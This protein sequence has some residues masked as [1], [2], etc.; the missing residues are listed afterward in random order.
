MGQLLGHFGFVELPEGFKYRDTETVEASQEAAR[1]WGKFHAEEEFRVE[2]KRRE[3]RLEIL[4]RNVPE[5]KT[6]IPGIKIGT[7]KHDSTIFD[8][9]DSNFLQ[10][11]TETRSNKP[12]E[13]IIVEETTSRN[14][15]RTCR[16]GILV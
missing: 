13:E 5:F 7:K 6:N 12:L 2:H 4:S 8:K 10:P 16:R 1:F 9:F 14:N 15:P 11:L 3:N